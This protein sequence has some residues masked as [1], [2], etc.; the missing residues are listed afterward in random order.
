MRS[1]AMKIIDQTRLESRFDMKH[2]GSE[3]DLNVSSIKISR[4][5]VPI[6]FLLKPAQKEQCPLLQLPNEPRQMN[7]TPC[8][9]P[10]HMR[11]T[12]VAHPAGTGQTENCYTL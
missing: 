3:E 1:S 7:L 2:Y 8:S 11:R 12:L 10:P 5:T 9:Y 4:A 6:S